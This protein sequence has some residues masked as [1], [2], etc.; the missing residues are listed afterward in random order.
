MKHNFVTDTTAKRAF[1][2]EEV[3]AIRHCRNVTKTDA[4]IMVEDE[5]G[6][7]ERTCYQ[8]LKEH[9]KTFR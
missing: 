7:P 5:Y 9:S 2:V 8:I 4:V 3:N 6:I 1:V